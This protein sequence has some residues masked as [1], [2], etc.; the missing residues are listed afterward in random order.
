LLNDSE[1]IRRDSPFLYLNSKAYLY[2]EELF[3]IARAAD[4]QA[5]KFGINI[6][7]SPQPTGITDLAAAAGELIIFAQHIDPIEKGRGHGALLPEAVKAAGAEGVVLNHAEKPLE[8]SVLS[9]TVARARALGLLTVIAAGS[10]REAAAAASL[11]PDMVMAEPAELIGSGK[12]SSSGY[13]SETL[14]S[15]KQVDPAI[16]VIQGA[17]ISTYEDA[18]RIIKAGADGVGTASGVFQADKPIQIIEEL[19][20]GILAGL[21]D[22][23]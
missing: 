1:A 16:K 2:G 22:S 21:E 9:R 15:V 8:L 5:K 13:I 3:E 11:A 17:G 20:Q 12:T 4:E 18:A 14:K 6:L 7:L 10:A 23:R 19:V